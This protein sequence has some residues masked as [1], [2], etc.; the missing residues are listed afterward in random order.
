MSIFCLLSDNLVNLYQAINK[1]ILFFQE[2]HCLDTL[3]V[4]T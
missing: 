1:E 3:I 4:S 2:I